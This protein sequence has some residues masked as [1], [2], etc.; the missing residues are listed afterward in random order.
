[1]IIAA[2][3][4]PA[5]QQILVFDCLRPGEV[6]RAQEVFKCASGKV[7]NVGLAL[8]YLG[9]PS[10]T[11][12]L[13]G[14]AEGESIEK[15]F[16]SL[17]IRRRWIWTPSST[18][19]C[20]T[21]LDRSGGVTT[22]LVENAAPVPAA[23]IGQFVAAYHEVVKQA[24]IVVL[25]GSIPAGVPKTFYRDLI[26]G[27]R[28]RVVLDASGAEL[29][30]ALPLKPFCVKP[31]RE[32]LGRTLGRNLETEEDLRRAIGE[33]CDLGAEWVVVSQGV[34]PL[35]V[36][37]RGKT[38]IFSPARV[39]S[40]NPIGSGDCLAA[41]LAWALKS[42]MGMFEAVQFGM[43]AAAENAAMMLPA[44]LNLERV[45]ARTSEI[46]YSEL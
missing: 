6:N 9:G 43:A 14:G 27:T 2:G 16:A 8:H 15:E 38:G 30:A 19:T 40:V 37:C 23:Q 35:W 21:I 12:A 20:V 31:N 28:A 32:E 17:G 44:R 13:V 7:L 18:R 24:E 3:L 36:G 39:H 4:T 34:K 25:S 42:G 41:G 46:K 29:F 45:R 10:L 33:V 5:Y 26:A 11:L 1:V 22:E